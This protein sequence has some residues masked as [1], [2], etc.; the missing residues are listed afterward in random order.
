M[1]IISILKSKDFKAKEKVQI[2][3]QLLLDNTID[4]GELIEFAL[5]LKGADKG[6][7]IESLEFAT[8]KSPSICKKETVI[9]IIQFLKDKEPRV[10]WESA[11]VISNVIDFFPELA[12]VALPYLYINAQNKGTVVRWSS[13]AAIR[14]IASLQTKKS[15]DLIKMI[16]TLLVKENKNSIQKIYLKALDHLKS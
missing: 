4:S 15:L 1:D 11:K 9:H 5:S 7:C 2:V 13:A 12:E 10:K 14:K 16:D 6:N 8:Q 3:A